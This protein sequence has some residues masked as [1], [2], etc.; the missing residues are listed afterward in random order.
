MR[1]DLTHAAVPS[2]PVGGPVRIRNRAENDAFFG[3]TIPDCVNQ[4]EL[5]PERFGVSPE[6]DHQSVIQIQANIVVGP[7]FEREVS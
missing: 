6:S 1:N 4:A 2:R 7:S 3:G 5:G